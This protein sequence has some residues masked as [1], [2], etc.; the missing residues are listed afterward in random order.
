MEVTPERV[1]IRMNRTAVA[2]LA[3]AG[4]IC[5]GGAV[6]VCTWLPVMFAEPLGWM[7]AC[8]TAAGISGFVTVL[9]ARRFFSRRVGLVIDRHGVIDQISYLGVGKIRWADIKRLRLVSIIGV[10][11]VV[12]RVYDPV[13]YIKR[14]NILQ[15][16]LKSMTGVAI[17]YPV[18]LTMPLFDAP[19]SEIMSAINQFF[20]QARGRRVSP[21][22]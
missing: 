2:L 3:I 5:T 20:D 1:R 10:K 18:T 17:G 9:L 8:S 4:F 7:I 15:R 22:A 16:C 13:R 12:I 21:P 6:W 14:G 11:F 19:A